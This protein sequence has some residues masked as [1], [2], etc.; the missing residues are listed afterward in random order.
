V[1]PLD[2][3]HGIL[4]SGGGPLGLAAVAGAGKYLEERKIGYDWGVPNI[5]VPIV[6][7]AVIDDLAVGNGTIRPDPEAAHKACEVARAG[8]VAE[9][10]VGAGAGATVGKMLR[11]QGLP[12]MKGGL[13]T[14]SLR[15]GEVVIGALAV[16]NAAGDI[17]EWRTGKTL[18]G[19]RRAD[20]R[21][22]AHLTEALKEGLAGAK[23]HAALRVDD[24]PFHSTTLAVVATNV[25]CSKTELTK[26]AMM[27]N[28]GAARAISPY[29]TTGDGDQIYA[30]STRKLKVDV[31]ISALGA[32]AGEVVA[33]A[34]G[35]AVKSATSIEGWPACE[36]FPPEP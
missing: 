20:G 7:G 17:L 9:G 13:G 25:A 12:G 11:S 29:H 10:N 28:C 22:F 3:I 15:L 36:D 30:L 34:I 33:E 35:R 14:A 1:S 24:A 5:R 18:A 2:N 32:I 27:A 21:G 8:P 23:P 6:V 31:P 26:I 4:F 16:V 19:A